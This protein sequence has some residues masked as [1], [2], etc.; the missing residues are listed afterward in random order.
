M[1]HFIELNHYAIVNW[2]RFGIVI[3]LER[4]HPNEHRMNV[5]FKKLGDGSERISMCVHPDRQEFFLLAPSFLPCRNKLAT[6][7]FTFVALFA[8][9]KVQTLRG[10]MLWKNFSQ[11]HFITL[12][13]DKSGQLFIFSKKFNGSTFA[14]ALPTRK[15]M[16][17]YSIILFYHII[18]GQI[19]TTLFF[20][21]ISV[22]FFTKTFRTIFPA[23]RLLNLHPTHL[24]LKAINHNL[25][26]Q[27]LLHL[28]DVAI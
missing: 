20:L 16:E 22:K 25:L 21:Q 28:L 14:K 4:F 8:L 6:A 13:R 19:G 18:P 5:D 26:Y 27:R 12:N 1:P 24:V 23:H 17:Y 2:S 9:Y 15:T 11:Y 10:E 7:F 3:F